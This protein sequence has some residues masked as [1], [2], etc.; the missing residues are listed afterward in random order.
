MYKYWKLGK[1]SKKRKLQVW[2]AVIRSKLTYGLVTIQINKDKANQLNAFQ[3][4]GIRR[5]LGWKTTYI[6]RE[7]TNKKLRQA[8]NTIINAGKPER[9]HKLQFEELTNRIKN[10]RIKYMGHLLRE[11]KN[12]PTRKAV[13]QGSVTPNLGWTKRTGRP[14]SNWIEET[15]REVWKRHRKVLPY[16]KRKHKN[17]NRKF[18]VS[19]NKVIRGILLGAQHRIF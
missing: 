16:G 18:R 3:L 2:N 9:K 4:K 14:R 17:K 8:A 10:D 13:M 5:I 12:E 11:D 7:N 1:C 6:E 15:L 19:D